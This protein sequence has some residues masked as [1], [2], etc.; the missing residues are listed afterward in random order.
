MEHGSLSDLSSSTFSLLDEDHTL[1]N[2]I[3]F[4]LNQ[5]PRVVFCGYSIPH[6]SD[7][8]VNI[9]VQ[10]TGDPAK[11]VLKDALENL[12]QMCQHVR[13]TFRETVDD[14]KAKN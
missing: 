4:T 1:A 2:S 6:P 11:D 8:K 9:R 12:T 13:S 10:T 14:F 3:R 7:N 5:D